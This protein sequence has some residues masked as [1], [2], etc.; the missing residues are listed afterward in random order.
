M[1]FNLYIILKNKRLSFG[2][3]NINIKM[4]KDGDEEQIQKF[5]GI[6][7]FNRVYNNLTECLDGYK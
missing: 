5:E 4:S 3:I 6:M 7:N 2:N 1:H